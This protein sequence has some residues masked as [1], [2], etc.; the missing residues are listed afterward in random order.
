MRLATMRGHTAKT[1]ALDS[2]F[3]HHAAHCGW[4]ATSL[5]LY[6]W[7]GHIQLNQQKL[8]VTLDKYQQRSSSD[9]KIAFRTISYQ[10]TGL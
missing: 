10:L 5:A 9:A 8:P 6:A 3:H 4:W 7:H 2:K 1:L